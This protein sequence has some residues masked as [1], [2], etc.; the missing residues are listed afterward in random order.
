[1][2]D[3]SSITAALSGIKN[4]TDI[5]NILRQSSVS[6]QDAEHR[7]K[8][9]ELVGALADVKMQLADVNQAV[10]DR[11]ARI[12][13]MKE[14]LSLKSKVTWERPYYWIVE[15]G[16]KDGPFCQHCYDSTQKTI[17]LQ[18]HGDGY[19]ECKTCRN[20]YRDKPANQSISYRSDSSEYP[21]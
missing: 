3:I 13:E 2:P 6:L 19:W 15:E 10:L 1:M 17:R 20:S 14:Q 21:F 11:D 18:G 8:L 7:L 4:A 12:A 16:K 9:A 5:V